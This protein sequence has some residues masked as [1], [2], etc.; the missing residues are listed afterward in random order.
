ML[1]YAARYP[2]L[3]ASELLYVF[4]PPTFNGRPQE[5]LINPLNGVPYPSTLGPRARAADQLGTVR[6]K[7][8]A[9]PTTSRSP[10]GP[11]LGE[12]EAFYQEVL[13]RAPEE[14][15]DVDSVV[16]SVAEIGGPELLALP[17]VVDQISY[18]RR[19]FMLPEPVPL[20]GRFLG[21]AGGN[22]LDQQSLAEALIQTGQLTLGPEAFT[23]PAAQ[24]ALAAALGGRAMSSFFPIAG[25]PPGGSTPFM[26]FGAPMTPFLGGDSTFNAGLGGVFGTLAQ[27]AG[28]FFLQ[29]QAA[30]QQE[31][32]IKQQIK[33]LMAQ[34]AVPVATP[35]GFAGPLMGP[36][37]GGLATGVG[38]AGA[39]GLINMLAGGPE[40][41]A[42]GAVAGGA[43]C[44]PRGAVSVSPMDAAGIYR[45][46]CGPCGSTQLITRNRFFALRSDGTKD[47][48]V[49]VGK[50]Q[51][52]S[53]RAL[54][55][56][57]RRWAKEARLTVSARG[58]RAK[59]KRRPR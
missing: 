10:G 32:L 22:V 3:A 41:T 36:L 6:S 20:T 12:Q 43:C 40:A 1:D 55:R 26:P 18:L 25:V 27:Q 19:V 48:F 24:A 56:F 53:P 16:R 29:Q 44:A 39:E 11:A 31:D 9:L 15:I 5:P 46:G 58:S 49:K 50:V 51:S 52:V 42:F 47:L 17:F 21:Q 45:T 14:N 7:L 30:K 54:N 33:L 8:R 59:G 13:M 2:E 4:S 35:M 23:S 34:A 38:A 37:L 57:A 28:Q